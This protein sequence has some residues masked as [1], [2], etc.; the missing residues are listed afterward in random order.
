MI[1]SIFFLFILYSFLNFSS[2]FLL[3]FFDI[4]LLQLY[5]GKLIWGRIDDKRRVE[6]LKEMEIFM[7]NLLKSSPMRPIVILAGPSKTGEIFLTK[8]AAL[9]NTNLYDSFNFKFD[10]EKDNNNNNN[11][12]ESN[13]EKDIENI[14][15]NL[16]NNNNNNNSNQNRNL[17]NSSP[18]D[19][20]TNNNN[21]NSMNH[22]ILLPGSN[23]IPEGSSGSSYNGRTLDPSSPTISPFSNLNSVVGVKKDR[24]PLVSMGVSGGPCGAPG[25][26]SFLFNLEML[27][28][29]E[30][31]NKPINSNLNT[32]INA[33]ANK[34][35]NTNNFISPYQ[36][37]GQREG[38]GQGINTSSPLIDPDSSSSLLL[39]QTHGHNS[40]L[41]HD[42]I[43]NNHN[44]L[45][46]Q[47]LQ[48]QN[49]INNNNI[50]SYHGL[51]SSQLTQR[52]LQE[53]RG[54]RPTMIELGQ[55]HQT[56]SEP[57]HGYSLAPRR[58]SLGD[59]HTL[60]ADPSSY[61]HDDWKKL[62]IFA[63]PQLDESDPKSLA[64]YRRHQ[65]ALMDADTSHN[66]RD[67]N[68]SY[69]ANQNDFNMN[70]LSSSRQYSES[71]SKLN[72]SSRS[73]N[74]NQAGLL[75]KMWVDRE[76]ERER[77]EESYY[78][79]L[80]RSKGSH[81]F[82]SPITSTTTTSSHHFDSL[83]HQCPTLSYPLSPWE[84]HQQQQQQR[85]SFDDHH[86]V[87]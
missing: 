64:Q 32:N 67:R 13:N 71:N 76:R 48:Q 1:N 34:G 58:H 60:G 53:L 24:T 75:D 9:E 68:L 28:N 4:T 3:L 17:N 14:N 43:N 26:P 2:L 86:N 56:V 46:K 21:T 6:K 83:N 47:Q 11:N 40:V 52:E 49:N 5:W 29:V 22:G 77:G 80:G 78:D 65:Q 84:Q 31:D 57:S 73:Q 23:L 59:G 7:P 38:Q 74:N 41:D 25:I 45:Y 54:R 70:D 82:Q 87:S 20:N 44:G 81:H 18:V 42:N 12:N 72:L 55:L 27:N 50:N 61:D 35:N 15:Q 37:K 8:E 30:C 10:I 79:S 19:S 69:L 51:R 36:H 33:T 66:Y 63:A 39:A 62:D 16:S 85:S